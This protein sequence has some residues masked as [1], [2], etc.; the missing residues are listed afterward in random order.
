[1][2]PSRPERAAA[3]VGGRRAWTIT[4]RSEFRDVRDRGQRRRGRRLVLYVLAGEGPARAG[5]VCG[6]AVGGAVQRNRARRILREAWRSVAPTVAPG[7][8]VII[9]AKSEIA[10]ARAHEVAAELTDLLRG[11]MEA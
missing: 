5:F 7:T 6:R 1:M 8:R 2:A 3:R 4:A 11:E 9:V 10:G